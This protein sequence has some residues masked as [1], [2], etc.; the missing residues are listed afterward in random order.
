MAK[1]AMSGAIAEVIDAVS[2][3][4]GTRQLLG[5]TGITGGRTFWLTGLWV[6][7]ASGPTFIMLLV[8]NA[9]NV[10]ATGAVGATSP[11]IKMRMW[12]PTASED[13]A[14]Y[15]GV[16]FR[17]TMYAFPPPGLKFTAGCC[18]LGESTCSTLS[19]GSFGGCGYEV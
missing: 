13:T 6:P 11:I 18:I 1:Y 10:G 19:V 14:T 12:L 8:D 17:K 16:S 9:T 5:G 7:Y 4:G 2:A 3:T 15:S